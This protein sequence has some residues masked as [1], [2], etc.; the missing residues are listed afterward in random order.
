MQQNV[1]LEPKDYFVKIS[2]QILPLLISL[3]VFFAGTDYK[4]KGN[5]IKHW[6]DNRVY[7]IDGS[8]FRA[9]VNGDGNGS[10]SLREEG[11]NQLYWL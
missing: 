9:V 1:L 5:E 7:W 2:L 8:V 4:F 11:R 3:S 10:Y 6:T